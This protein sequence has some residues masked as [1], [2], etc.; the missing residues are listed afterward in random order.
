M[1][2]IIPLETEDFRAVV[3]EDGIAHIIM[4]KPDTM[5]V[6]TGSGHREL[7]RIWRV[8]N[9]DP[10]V[11]AI[12]VRS[13]GKGFCAGGTME[14]VENLTRSHQGRLALYRELMDMV[15]GMINCDKPIV[16]AINGAAVGAGLALGLLSDIS[17]A[18][19]S[20]KLIDG[21]TRLGIAAGDHAVLLWPLLCGMAKAKHA[22]L[23]CE[24]LT[25]EEAERIGLVSLCVD[26]PDLNARTREIAARL[27]AGSPTALAWTKR[28]LNHWF[29]AAGPAFEHAAALE[30][31]GFTGPDV[32]EGLA[33]VKDKRAPDFVR[34]GGGPKQGL[35]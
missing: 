11:R 33:A 31:L 21:H 24:T 12:L 9:D 28:A 7:G 14:L 15:W 18:V 32:Q 29:R 16:S 26:A 22:L 34:P 10:E 20:A 6:L 30:V 8:L 13:E 25:G 4:G 1:S 2:R 3:E 27:A 35:D 5:P 23:L 19:R 17:V